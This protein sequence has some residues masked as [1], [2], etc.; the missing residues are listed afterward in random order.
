MLLEPYVRLN[1]VNEV[2]SFVSFDY[3]FFAYVA[4]HPKLTSVVAIQMLDLLARQYLN[5]LCNSSAVAVPFMMLCSRF[6]GTVHCQEFILKYLT[7]SLNQLLLIDN[8][9][10]STETPQPGNRKMLALP[11]PSP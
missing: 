9:S 1:Q 2:F 4:Q 10:G 11:A 3:D 5:D 6:I 7:I 8:A